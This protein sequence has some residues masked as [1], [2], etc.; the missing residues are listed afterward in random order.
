MLCKGNKVL[1]KCVYTIR[2]KNR[3]KAVDLRTLSPTDIFGQ[4]TS[5]EHS[6]I[7]VILLALHFRYLFLIL[8][9][10]LRNITYCAI[11]SVVTHVQIHYSMSKPVGYIKQIPFPCISLF[12]RDPNVIYNVQ[13]TY[14]HPNTG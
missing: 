8:F 13:L 5:L 14:R 10:C 6:W 11:K 2:Y 4:W 1:K 3:I 12:Q 7:Q 9:K